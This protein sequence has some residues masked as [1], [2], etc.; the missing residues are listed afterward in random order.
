LVDDDDRRVGLFRRKIQ[1]SGNTAPSTIFAS[2]WNIFEAAT[3]SVSMDTMRALGRRLTPALISGGAAIALNT[4]ALKAA[5]LV[6]L[7]TAKGGLLRLLSSWCSGLFEAIG[8]A[9]AWSR[10]GA[11]APD[12]PLFQTGFHLL[13]GIMMALFYA[14]VL[15]PVLPGK[16]IRKG[17]IYAIA[18]WLLNAIIVLPATGEGFAGSAHLTLA[19]IVWFAAAHSLFFMVLAVLYGAIRHRLS[20]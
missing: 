18:I 17:A 15:E 12:S 5:D 19:G 4:L 16:V 6:P 1:I 2:R 11:P 14:Y 8:I 3:S 20:V 7:A 13:V 10:S 9:S